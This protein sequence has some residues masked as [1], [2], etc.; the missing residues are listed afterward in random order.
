MRQPAQSAPIPV[1]TDRIS[2]RALICAVFRG[3]GYPK[4]TRARPR[5]VYDYELELI[6]EGSGSYRRPALPGQKG[7]VL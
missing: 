2:P 3:T 5:Y 7:D 1:P 6:L 4:G